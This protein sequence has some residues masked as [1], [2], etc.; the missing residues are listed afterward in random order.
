MI[1]LKILSLRRIHD[2]KWQCNKSK[3]CK[4]KLCYPDILAWACHSVVWF[5]TGQSLFQSEFSRERAFS[6]SC[7]NVQYFI[8]SLR[9][10]SSCL[11]L[12]PRLSVP[13]NFPSVSCFIKQFLR[14]IYPIQWACLHFIVGKMLLSSL[15]L[16]DTSK[17]FKRSVQL[18]FSSTIFQN[19][20]NISTKTS[21]N[22]YYAL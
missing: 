1:C 12:L 10:C 6:A 19:I 15:T 17:F 13:S 7:F 16:R 3:E 20:L 5:T 18:I 8:V 22:R 9:S 2:G 11:I 4:Q 14:S 21:I